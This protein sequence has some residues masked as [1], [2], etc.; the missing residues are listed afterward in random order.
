M[1]KFMKVL[2]GA[3]AVIGGIAGVLYFLDKKKAD[4]DFADFDDD[5][6]DD[7]FDDDD[8]DDRDYVTLDMESEEE[9]E[10]EDGKEAEAAP[11]E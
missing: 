11:Q 9:A 1:K 5:D 7:V 4:D 2:L 6:F 3:G 10:G 8:D